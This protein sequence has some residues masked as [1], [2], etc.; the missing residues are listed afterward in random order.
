[1]W[2]AARGLPAPAALT[3]A[4][5]PPPPKPAP[6]A[7]RIAGAIRPRIT[8]V[9]ERLVQTWRSVPG[10]VVRAASVVLAILAIAEAIFIGRLLSTRIR[11]ISGGADCGRCVIRLRRSY[12]GQVHLRC[13]R[14]TGF[15][16]S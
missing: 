5:P 8:S 10:P 12:G 16:G 3:P 13:S 14:R 2:T 6:I 1:M 7:T 9:R 4:L 11:R 15:C